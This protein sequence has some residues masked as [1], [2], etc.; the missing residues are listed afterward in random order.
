MGEAGDDL[1]RALSRRLES[2][3]PVEGLAVPVGWVRDVDPDR[4]ELHDTRRRGEVEHE[5]MDEMALEVQLYLTLCTC[6]KASEFKLKATS[7]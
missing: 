1:V 2:D 4:L 6:R 7:A 3:G 5:R